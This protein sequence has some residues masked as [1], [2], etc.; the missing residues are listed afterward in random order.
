MTTT[1]TMTTPPDRSIKILSRSGNMLLV[2]ISEPARRQE[3]V[4]DYWLTSVQTDFGTAYRWNHFG[5]G[6]EYLSDPS[7]QSCTCKHAQ[8]RRPG[9]KPCRHLASLSA[10]GCRKLLPA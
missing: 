8:H 5:C 9:Q 3:P 7:A 4:A 2:R 6:Q 10:L 1:T